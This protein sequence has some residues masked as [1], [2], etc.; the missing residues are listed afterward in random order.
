MERGF[1]ITTQKQNAKGSFEK[2]H[3]FYDREC[4]NVKIKGTICLFFLYQIIM[5]YEFVP[6]EQIVNEYSIFKFW[7]VYNS[8]FVEKDQICVPASEFCIMTMFLS[9]PALFVKRCLAKNKYHCWNIHC[10]CLIWLCV[11]FPCSWN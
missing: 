3:S 5:H 9:H 1:S 6:S 11:T 7:N 10:T 8:A 2:V 4:T